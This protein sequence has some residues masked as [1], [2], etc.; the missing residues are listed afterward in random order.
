M[1]SPAPRRARHRCPTRRRRLPPGGPR[2][3]VPD[4][5]RSAA[6]LIVLLLGGPAG[7]AVVPRL[8]ADPVAAVAW[9]PSTGLLVAEIVTGGASASDEY[10]EL[11]NA[12]GAPLDL[13][14]LEVAY[15]TSSGA[16]VT[17]KAGWTADD[18]RRAGPARPAREQPRGVRGVGGHPVLGRARGDGRR[19]RPPPDR[20]DGD[21]RLGWGDA[22]NTFVEGTA[23]AAPAPARR[24]SDGPVAS[25][26]QRPGHERQRGGPRVERAPVAQNLAAAPVP[27]AGPSPSPTARP[28]PSPDASPV[29][30]PTPTPTP[31]PT[32]T[33]T[34]LRHRRPCRRP[35]DAAS[36]PTRRRPRARRRSRPSRRRRAHACSDSRRTPSPTPCHRRPT[37]AP[38]PTPAT[39]ADAGPEPDADAVADRRADPGTDA[40]VAPTPTPRP[41]LAIEAAR[42]L[43]DEAPAR[44]RARS[45]LR[46]GRSRARAAASSRTPTAGI[47]LYLDAAFEAPLPAGTT[48]RVAGV[49]DSRYGQ[50]TLRVDAADVEITGSVEIPVRARRR[51]RRGVGA[52][53]GPAARAH[54][55]GR[56]DA[57][58]LVR[59]ARDHDRRRHRPRAGH[60]RP[61]CAR[62]ARDRQGRHRGRSRPARP[63]GQLGHRHDRL[64]PPRDAP[65]RARASRRAVADAEPSPDLLADP[66]AHVDA[67][68][69]PRAASPYAGHHPDARADRRAR[70]PSPRRRPARRRSRSPP[71]GPCRSSSRLFTRGVV[72]ADAGRL[73]TPRLLAIA[74]ATG[75]IAVRL[76]DGVALPARG[77]LLEVRGAMADPYGQLELRP[78]ATG[79]AVVGTAPLPSPMTIAAGPSR[80]VDR[81]PP[82][83]DPGTSPRP[84]P[85]RPA[86]TSRSRSPGRTARRSACWPTRARTSTSRSCARAPPRRSRGS[87]ASARPARASST[88]TGCGSGIAPTSASLTQPGPVSSSATPKPSGSAGSGRRIG[89]DDRDR[90][91]PRRQRP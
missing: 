42:Q 50:R 30:T 41:L 64:P 78:T 3:R 33:P 88:A 31:V 75:G 43:P 68:A 36:T 61:G 90:Q 14:G 35:S 81:R 77:T 65:W 27:G 17:K 45:P 63:A 21:R 83:D 32:P 6:M 13:A 29:P 25:G 84:R 10:V 82:R 79:I 76:P 23:A 59:R 56:R 46:S 70:R 52:A 20:R 4:S 80:R 7:P 55:L 16:T 28:P 38:T 47:A 26:G 18:H 1:P 44:S 60:R 40:D 85:R 89:R 22:T 39:D 19:D 74:D 73:G 67:R 69:E 8:A 34:P 9:P 62:A 91:G 37:P 24:S 72:V 66:R 58:R 54:G 11:D 5:R 15:V 57:V 49:L 86:A 2:W 87:W 48:I 51:H 12:S 71:P 53:R